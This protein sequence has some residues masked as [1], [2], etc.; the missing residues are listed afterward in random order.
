[1]ATTIARSRNPAIGGSNTLD[2]RSTKHGDNFRFPFDEPAKITPLSFN[3]N[4]P[5]F[6]QLE[7]GLAAPYVG[8]FPMPST[9]TSTEAPGAPPPP[10]SEVPSTSLAMWKKRNDAKR[11][12]SPAS[13]R[14]TAAPESTSSENEETTPQGSS[15]GVQTTLMIHN[16]PLQYTQEMLM[17]EWP[18]NGDY[19]FLYLPLNNCSNRNLTYAF[20]N[21]TS[22]QAACAFQSRWQNQYLKHFHGT[23]PLTLTLADVQGRE[24]NLMKLVEKRTPKRR[25]KYPKSQRCQPMVFEGGKAVPLEKALN[26]IHSRSAFPNFQ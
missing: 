25:T 7:T 6:Q 15:D 26:L 8:A 9:W 20:V 12:D 16:I 2:V 13:D 14:T 10:A 11:N 3:F 4:Y 24:Q 17:A 18:N 19:D 5:Y 23:S 21:F 1:M 22:T